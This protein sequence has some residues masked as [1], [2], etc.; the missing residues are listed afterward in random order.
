MNIDVKNPGQMFLYFSNR[1][2]SKKLEAYLK[3]MLRP[4]YNCVL[5]VT[6]TDIAQTKSKTITIMLNNLRNI[7]KQSYM[8]YEILIDRFFDLSTKFFDTGIDRRYDIIDRTV[9]GVLI[10]TENERIYYFSNVSSSYNQVQNKQL[11]RYDTNSPPIYKLYVKIYNYILILFEIENIK[12][13]YYSSTFDEL[14]DHVLFTPYSGKY[15]ENTYI[16]HYQ[17]FYFNLVSWN[18]EV[19]NTAVSEGYIYR[20]LKHSGSYLEDGIRCFFRNYKY[21]RFFP[22]LGSTF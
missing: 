16:T 2:L 19:T 17:D 14:K 9:K 12:V 10:S 3:Y 5:F 20:S 21:K 15:H 13:N 18:S 1:D 6:T 11:K 22:R 7:S 4:L 8:L